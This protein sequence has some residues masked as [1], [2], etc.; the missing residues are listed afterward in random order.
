MGAF[1]L[2]S[3]TGKEFGFL[4]VLGILVALAVFEWLT[5]RVS[6]EE[7]SEAMAEAAR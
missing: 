2:A 6:L 1:A 3:Y 7:P 4:A 5:V